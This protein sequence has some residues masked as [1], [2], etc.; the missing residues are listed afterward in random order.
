MASNDRR[1]AETIFTVVDVETTGLEPEDRVIEVA[2]LRLQGDREL[3]RFSGLVNPGIHIPS[4]ASSISGIDDGMVA[5]AP[6]FREVWP[7]LDALFAGAVLVAHNAP[8]DLHFLSSERKRAELP[9]SPT[10][11]VLDTLRLARN[12]LVMRRYSLA[13]LVEELGIEHPPAHRALADALATAALLRKLLG[14]LG[15]RAER[16][17]DLLAAQEPQPVA[18]EAAGAAGAGGAFI[19]PLQA[20]AR[21]EQWVEVD[22]DARHGRQRLRVRPLALE[23]NG[24]LY[25]LRAVRSGPAREPAALRLD[26]IREIL[27]VS[28][29]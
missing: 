12:L 28:D 21:A 5:S 14:I 16:L 18:W 23:R 1:V 22:Y 2:A 6:G 26:R 9:A 11:P 10:G 3:G 8:F 7:T 24:P 19:E 4:L 15:E 13:V 29:E 20:A 17:E 25:Y 27:S